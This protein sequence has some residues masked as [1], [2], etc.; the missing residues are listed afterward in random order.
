MRH[1]MSAGTN[2]RTSV[3]LVEQL[4]TL[5]FDNR[6]FR[7][8]HHCPSATLKTHISYCNRVPS[9]RTGGANA[10]VQ[11][12][13]ALVLSSYERGGFSSEARRRAVLLA[14]AHAAVAEIPK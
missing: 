5:G 12:R 4:I 6:T 3:T 1:K 9:F 7:V 8:L 14:L 2:P 13:L 10:K 11:T